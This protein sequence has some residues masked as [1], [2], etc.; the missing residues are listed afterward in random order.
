MTN[1]IDLCAERIRQCRAKARLSQAEVAD[2]LGVS[3]NKVG[4]WERAEASPSI[5][6]AAQLCVLFDVSLEYL[7][8]RS[9]S[10]TGLTPG[11]WLIDLDLVEKPVPEE[12]WRAEVPR[13]HRIVS[14]SEMAA[15][16]N[17]KRKGKKA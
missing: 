10:P 4:T 9:D 13:R 15:I 2:R 14:Y 1:P 16:A 3:Q 11:T 12:T 5:L 6:E 17:A 8:G 7:A